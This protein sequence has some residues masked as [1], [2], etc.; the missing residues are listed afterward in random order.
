MAVTLDA[1]TQQVITLDEYVDFIS[2]E[3][4][5]DDEASI[6]AS[7]PMLRALANNRGA[8]FVADVSAHQQLHRANADARPDGTLRRT[9]QHLGAARR[10]T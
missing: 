4:D 3:V 9:R 1:D 7:A 5:A 8:P 2:R 10:L 6:L